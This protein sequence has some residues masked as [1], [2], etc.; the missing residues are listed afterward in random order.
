MKRYKVKQV[1]EMLQQEGWVLDRTKGDHRQFEP[2]PA[3]QYMETGWVEIDNNMG[4]VVINIDWLDHNFG[5]APK[6]EE[7]A[8][9]ATGK[10]LEEVKATIV[11]ALQFH[12]EGMRLHEE[13]IPEEFCGEWEPEFVLTTR[14]QIRYSDNYI[15]RKALSKETGINIQ[16]LSH[17]ANGWKI[18]RPSTRKKIADGIIAISKRLTCIL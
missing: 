17:Y 10:T 8:C 3:E 18:P 2:V 9:V 7:I 13:E 14:A 12:L 6:N 5:A 16:Q 1:I 4:K 11:E 15:T